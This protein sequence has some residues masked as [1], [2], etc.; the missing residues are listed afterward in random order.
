LEGEIM[1]TDRAIRQAAV[2]A[3]LTD[4]NGLRLKVAATASGGASRRWSVRFMTADGRRQEIGLGSYPEVSLAEA[5]TRAAALRLQART[6]VDPLAERRAARMKEAAPPAAESVMT[7]RKAAEAYLAQHESQWSNA[8]HRHQWRKALTDYAAPLGPTPV[9]DID[10]A[11]VLRVLDPM[12]VAKPE[13]A[14]R[15]RQRIEAVLD[16]AMARGHRPEGLNPARLKGNLAY[17]LPRARGQHEHHPALPWRDVPRFWQSL[18]M[19]QGAG[20]DALRFLLLTAARS[21]EVR[22][23]TW[24]EIDFDAGLWTVPPARMKARKE[25]RVPLSGPALA[26]LRARRDAQGGQG[27][28]FPSDMRP[29]AQ[30][31]DMTIAAVMRRMGL[32]AVPHGLRSTFRDWA[33]EATSYPRDVCEQALAHAIENRVEAAYRRG[34]MLEKRRRLMDDWARFVTEGQAVDADNVRPIRGLA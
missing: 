28:I 31:S 5:R 14:R 22:G 3:T 32:D 1:L 11:A 19:R 4:V 6:G 25:H 33:A 23:S 9:A 27:L 30:V 29:G 15:V 18:A 20:A 21:G 12:W 2:P 10:A 16:W 34:D 7:F 24:A 8:K 26:L 13:T 17:A